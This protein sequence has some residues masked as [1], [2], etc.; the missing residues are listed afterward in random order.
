MAVIPHTETLRQRFF[1]ALPGPGGPPGLDPAGVA[2]SWAL[3]LARTVARLHGAGWY[4]RDLYLQHCV[5]AVSPGSP[6]SPGS[7]A[8]GP[9]AARIVLLD[10]GRARRGARVR[11][12]WFEKDLAALAASA[13]ESL[14]E[15]LLGSLIPAYLEARGLPSSGA[16]SWGRWVRWRA[17][18]MNARVPRHTDANTREGH[19]TEGEVDQRFLP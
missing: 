2:R 9:D 6:A 14:R 11:R 13:P 16:R 1:G 17:R 8:E 4:H 7:T 3:P 10:F 18:R 5:L 12:R 19:L 15:A